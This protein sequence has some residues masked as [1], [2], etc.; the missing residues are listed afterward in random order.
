MKEDMIFVITCIVLYK[1]FSYKK[2]EEAEENIKQK[3][4]YVLYFTQLLKI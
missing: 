2:T 3:I 4:I 1:L